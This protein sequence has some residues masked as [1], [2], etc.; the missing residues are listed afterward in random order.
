MLE[1][2]RELF[3]Q[4]LQDLLSMDYRDVDEPLPNLVT[5]VMVLSLWMVSYNIQV[6]STL[7]F[8]RVYFFN[9][10]CA[11]SDTFGL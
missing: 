2:N 11:F 4:K 10:G 1:F 6:I 7:L 3:L 9:K 8:K 5:F